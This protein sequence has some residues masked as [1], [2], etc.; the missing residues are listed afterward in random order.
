MYDNEYFRKWG[1]HRTYLLTCFSPLTL[2]MCAGCEETHKHT[3]RIKREG[4]E[5]SEEKEKKLPTQPII[6]I[7]D[8]NILG[9][10]NILCFINLVVQQPVRQC[11]QTPFRSVLSQEGRKTFKANPLFQELAGELLFHHLNTRHHYPP[12]LS[13]P[14]S[15]GSCYHLGMACTLLGRKECRAWLQATWEEEK[16]KN[17][18]DEQQ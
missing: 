6:S 15:L 18:W 11:G 17:S 7:M 12:L 16:K 13:W 10:L 3:E 4:K 1:I 2:S 5:G 14:L 8:K 9:W